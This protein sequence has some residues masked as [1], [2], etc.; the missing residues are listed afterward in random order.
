MKKIL[1][2]FLISVPAVSVAKPKFPYDPEKAVEQIIRS[3][4]GKKI[5]ENYDRKSVDHFIK[6]VTRE[7]YYNCIA[8]GTRRLSTPRQP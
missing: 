1:F 6:T 8:S 7:Y 3:D 4:K 2:L 5:S